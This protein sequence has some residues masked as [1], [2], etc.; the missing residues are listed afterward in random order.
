MQMAY[1]IKHG[2]HITSINIDNENQN[3]FYNFAIV[4]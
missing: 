3:I 2:N 1:E 4:I